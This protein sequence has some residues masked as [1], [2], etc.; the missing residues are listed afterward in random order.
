MATALTSVKEPAGLRERLVEAAGK[1]F[2]EEGYENLSMRR[3]AQEVGCSQMAV[4]RYFTNKEALIQHLCAELYLRFALRMEKEMQIADS[5]WEKLRIFIAALIRFAVQYPDHYSL[6]FLVRHPD[7]SVLAEREKLGREFIGGIRGLVREVLPKK[8]P[9]AVVEI[10]L[11]QMFTCLHGAAA[12][13]IA[14][15]DAY[16]LTRKNTIRETE[17]TFQK[18]LGIST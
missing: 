15:P 10:R 8:T 2:L 13:L 1:I 6:V 18:L 12:L 11:R 4:Y 9:E 16:G 3:V 5:P 7:P 14:H 17:E